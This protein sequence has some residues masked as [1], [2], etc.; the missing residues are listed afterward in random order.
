[1]DVA[2]H[3]ADRIEARGD[4][5]GQAVDVDAP[6][7]V[8]PGGDRGVERHPLEDVAARR[9]DVDVQVLGALDLERLEPLDDVLGPDAV[10]A[11][12]GVMD[13]EGTTLLA[14][15]LLYAG[16]DARRSCGH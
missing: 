7:P 5:R 6:L 11:A 10:P 15:A 9:V 12:D 3:V 1:V 16:E 14:I 8:G 13:V 2:H 4:A